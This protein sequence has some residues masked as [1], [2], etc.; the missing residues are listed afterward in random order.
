MGGL[1]KNHGLARSCIKIPLTLTDCFSGGLPLVFH[2]KESATKFYS[3]VVIDNE[4]THSVWS[5]VIEDTRI[6]HPLSK[7]LYIDKYL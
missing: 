3:T 4:A 1:D 6:S 7:I 5:V 2:G